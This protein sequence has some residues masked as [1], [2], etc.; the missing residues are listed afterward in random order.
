[1]SHRNN[2]ELAVLMTCAALL[3]VAVVYRLFPFWGDLGLRKGL[4]VTRV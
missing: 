4:S 3:A 2:G 1:L